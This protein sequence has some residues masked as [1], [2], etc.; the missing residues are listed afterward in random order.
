MEETKPA[1]GKKRATGGKKGANKKDHIEDITHTDVPGPAASNE[2]KETTTVEA[3]EVP[4]E[5]E[6]KNQIAKFNLADAGIDA[7][8]QQYGELTI[9]DGD[10][11]AYETVKKAWGLV[12][13][14]RTGLEK[15]G[16]EL[17]T[18]YTV[19]TK[20]IKG[21][22]DRLIK[23]LTPL[24][25]D[26]EKKWRA[27]DEAKEAEKKRKQQ[28]EEQQLN[29][30]LEELM[31]LGMKFKDGFYQLGDTI[32]MDV[33]TLRM[34]PE[35]QYQKL[36]ATVKVKA[37]ELEKARIAEESRKAEEQRKLQ[38]EQNKLLE[39]QNKLKQQQQEL[40][41]QKK[42]LQK[43]KDEADRLRRENR[44]NSLLA[45][46]FIP[47]QDKSY[48][49]KTAIMQEELRVGA[50]ILDIDADT[51][52]HNMQAYK[53]AIE[54]ENTRMEE[55]LKEQRR[56]VELLE[57]RV[58]SIVGRMAEEGITYYESSASFKHK[59][60]VGEIVVYMKDLLA[61]DDTLLEDS[62]KDTVAM[63]DHLVNR[64]K[65]ADVVKEQE[66]V[67]EEERK[68]QERLA[69]MSDNQILHE[70]ITVVQKQFNDGIKI[71]KLKT[72]KGKT[73]AGNLLVIV[74]EQFNRI[75]NEIEAAKK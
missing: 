18:G 53:A 60:E 37:E 6:I 71:S 23:A 28:E 55:H 21:E 22:E 56:K 33:V 16:L 42:E 62:I 31:G 65:E 73:S 72:K 34:L 8:K 13:S 50:D 58:K 27:V 74:N 59:E 2:T 41:D 24:E 20:A 75:L 25:E 10:K 17:R 19:I 9:P 46:G 48:K 51:F 54:T 29:K 38:E 64:Q 11:A 35:D 7:L 39:E 49:F 69:D 68:E 15:K 44:N 47:M 26:L 63:R 30:R 14:T 36:V 66:R 40:E 3:E 57:T 4:V 43:Q 12:R 5:V 32:S 1:P 52:A 67:K 70:M 61:V 45:A